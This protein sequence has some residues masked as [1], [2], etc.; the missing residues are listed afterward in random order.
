MEASA[1]MKWG[2]ICS[3][4]DQ[5]N[6]K[7]YIDFSIWMVNQLEISASKLQLGHR[8]DETPTF[9][10]HAIPGSIDQSRECYE[11]IAKQ[12]PQVIYVIHILPSKDSLEYQILK[13]HTLAGAL[14]G[15]GVLAENALAYFKCYE[16]DEVMANMNQWIGRRLAQITARR[17][18][19]N[20]RLTVATGA[21]ATNLFSGGEGKNNFDRRSPSF[22]ADN[23]FE[24]C[25]DVVLHSSSFQNN[26]GGRPQQTNNNI[27]PFNVRDLNSCNE[28]G[29]E[30][31][32]L[33]KG[34]PP[35]FNK[36]QIASLFYNFRP[37]NVQYMEGGETLIQF[38][39]KFHAVQVIEQYNGRKYE[40]E[41][42][43]LQVR[44]AAKDD[45][46]QKIGA[47]KTK[48]ASLLL[49]VTTS[50]AVGGENENTSVTS[51]ENKEGW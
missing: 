49:M 47:V 14:V 26:F 16:L 45:P 40:D 22:N 27:K 42:F 10:L 50:K 48:L 37:L 30:N 19:D 29:R 28:I 20:Y 32:V 4:D 23:N 15:Q 6:V 36:Y 5:E 43:I 21:N 25:V 12:H 11:T 18:K 1:E 51:E 39:N 2:L 9:V 35:N 46:T 38:A 34:Y 44:A 24:Q 13:E 31:E 17:T 8:F 33:V 3:I 41:G 7:K